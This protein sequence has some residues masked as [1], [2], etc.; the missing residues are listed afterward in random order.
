MHVTLQ[1]KVHS[2][3]FLSNNDVQRVKVTIVARLSKTKSLE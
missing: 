2:G 3:N 1:V